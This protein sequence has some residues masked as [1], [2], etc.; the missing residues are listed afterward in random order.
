MDNNGDFDFTEK[1]EFSQR[2][3]KSTVVQVMYNC[4]RLKNLMSFLPSS[5]SHKMPF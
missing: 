2:C 1:M 5:I 4:F 3:F